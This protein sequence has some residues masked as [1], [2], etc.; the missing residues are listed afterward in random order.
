MC[1]ILTVW[2]NLLVAGAG[3]SIPTMKKRRMVVTVIP[4]GVILVEQAENVLNSSPVPVRARIYIP[5]VLVVCFVIGGSQIEDRKL[6]IA[7]LQ[8]NPTIKL[9]IMN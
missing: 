4:P 8:P 3:P 2:E 1:F 6:T 5:V 9:Q 7:S